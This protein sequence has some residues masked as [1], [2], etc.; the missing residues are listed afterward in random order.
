MASP[1][2]FVVLPDTEV[3][4]T[5]VH[6]AFADGPT[7]VLKHP[8]GRP[9]IV[10]NLIPDQLR[11]SDEGH[12]KWALIGDAGSAPRPTRYFGCTDVMSE[13]LEIPGSFH[14]IATQH[15][16]VAARGTIAG[17]RSLFWAELDGTPLISDRADLLAEITNAPL[18]DTALALRLIEFLPASL[19]RV[20]PWSGVRA[21]PG[22]RYARIDGTSMS[23]PEWWRHPRG[24]QS[25][26]DG[27]AAFRD[28]LRDAVA[29]RCDKHAVLSADLS[30]GMDSTPLCLM[31]SEQADRLITYTSVG[32]D[33]ADDD[34][35]YVREAGE[36]MS[37]RPVRSLTQNSGDLPIL[38]EGVTNAPV[39]FDEPT[40]SLLSQPR[41]RAYFPELLREGSRLHLTGLG[42]DHV[43][44]GLPQL[45]H[46]LVTRR[47]FTALRAMRGYAIL[48]RWSP[49][50]S[51]RALTD[52]RTYRRWMQDTSR[53]LGRAAPLRATPE[54]GWSVSPKWPTWATQRALELVREAFEAASTYEALSDTRSEHFELQAIMHGGQVVRAFE[55]A[56][57]AAGLPCAS[58]YLDD[59]VINAALSVAPEDRATPF[60]FK[61][62]IK[63]AL[64]D[65][66]PSGLRERRTKA[67]GGQISHRGRQQHWSTIERLWNDS[68]LA[69]RNLIDPETLS[70]ADFN[71]PRLRKSGAEPINATVVTEIWTRHQQGNPL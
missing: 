56:G 22:G 49:G 51:A 46:S 32:I 16:E 71:D 21:V 50:E 59:R 27:S 55:H 67:D 8:S 10:G 42:G 66:L 15:G 53:D 20:P 47:P 65:L 12:L 14:A 38:F 9:W 57:R 40:I 28:A 31:A 34:Q 6:K 7:T 35:R 37:G 61:P 33:A 63:A 23:L 11:A 2:S 4:T 18:D 36:L 41:Q 30:G 29:A 3:D 45:H 44:W 69:H 48:R 70:A 54:F 58:P 19:Q 17:I 43:L 1:G 25:L 13:T 62:L 26:T 5:A 60:E 52:R 24:R 68:A 64:G 39:P